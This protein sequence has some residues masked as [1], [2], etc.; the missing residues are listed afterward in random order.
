MIETL[1]YSIHYNRM[2]LISY[3]V[4][5]GTYRI[6]FWKHQTF[7]RSTILIIECA[8]IDTLDTPVWDRGWPTMHN[9]YPGHQWKSTSPIEDLVC[10]S[11]LAIQN[12]DYKRVR[13]RYKTSKCTVAWKNGDMKLQDEYIILPFRFNEWT[14]IP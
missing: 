4:R 10:Y 8:E 6:E 9:R 14:E 7:I 2:L 13:I 5:S 1:N 3:I 11:L 12:F